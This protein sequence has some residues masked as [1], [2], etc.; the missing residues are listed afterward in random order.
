[1]LIK[2]IISL[3]LFKLAL[4]LTT[5]MFLCVIF[6]RPNIHGKLFLI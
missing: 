1:M 4:T 2:L 6:V 3:I 5:Y